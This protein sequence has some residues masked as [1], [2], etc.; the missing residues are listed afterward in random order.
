[1]AK[2]NMKGRFILLLLLFTISFTLAESVLSE[3][4]VCCE[5]TLEGAWCQ[6]VPEAECEADVN[7]APTSCESASYCKTGT[8]YDSGEGLCTDNVP[9]QVCD[10]QGGA[11]DARE[12]EEVPQCQLGCCLITDQAAFVSLVR[13]KRLSTY[14]GTEINYLT[15]INDEFSCIAQAQAQDKG[16]CVYEKDFERLCEFTTRQDC[17][18]AET[19]AIIENASE[20]EV[21]LSSSKKFYQDYLCSAEELATSCAK[22]VETKCYNGKTYY[23]DS[24]GNP[25]NVYSKN[26]AE[27]WNNGR[28]AEPVEVCEPVGVKD[29]GKKAE[30]GNCDYLLGTRCE[31][32]EK[33]GAYCQSTTCEDSEGNPRKNGEAW[34]VNDESATGEGKDRVGSKYI[35]EVCR[36]GDVIV[37]QCADFRNEICISD[38]VDTEG[39]DFSTA[40]CRVNRWQD[41]LFQ[42]EEDDCENVD[43][44]DCFWT[45]STPQ[46]LFITEGSGQ[47]T[48]SNPTSG[49]TAFSNPTNTITGNALFGGGDDEEEEV[50]AA[51]G[52]RGDGVCLPANT[53]GLKFWEESSAQA[54]CSQSS[55][56]CLVVWTKGLLDSGWECVEGCECLEAAWAE[57]INGICT[58]VG[59]CGGA[60]NYKGAE[61]DDGYEYKVDGEKMTISEIISGAT[62]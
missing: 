34:C 41:C 44:R 52:N 46:G 4:T 58:S 25:E 19:I 43:K 2:N 20:E 9:K 53:P 27:S 35:R 36:D 54:I 15:N 17:G 60:A 16:A 61:T 28:T 45:N 21:E 3:P 10:E 48:F 1:M 6:N 47:T 55:A 37:E 8:C 49:N 40:V 33:N 23:F 57:E 11:W 14:F 59:D 24:C 26:S 39:G 29:A 50:T 32:D 42:I 56:E 7:A 5:K 62:K 13:C 30:C 31:E 12:I 38:S 51:P 18:A 22:Q